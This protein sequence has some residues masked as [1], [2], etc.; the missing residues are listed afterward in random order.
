[1]EDLQPVGVMS[2][3]IELEFDTPGHSMSNTEL[4]GQ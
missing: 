1:M 3:N 4:T 2:F